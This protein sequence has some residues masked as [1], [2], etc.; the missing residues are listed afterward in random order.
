[1]LSLWKRSWKEKDPSINTQQKT[2]DGPSSSVSSLDS[3]AAAHPSDVGRVTPVLAEDTGHKRRYLDSI[4]LDDPPRKK[5]RLHGTDTLLNAD[6]E[7]LARVRQENVILILPSK[8]LIMQALAPS[9]LSAVERERLRDSSITQ[10]RRILL[11][12]LLYELLECGELA[13]IQ[14][15]MLIFADLSELGGHILAS[16]QMVMKNF[17]MAI[18]QRSRPRVLGFLPSPPQNVPSEISDLEDIMDSKVRHIYN[19]PLN[20]PAAYCSELVLIY[21]RTPLAVTSILLE[22][23]RSIDSTDAFVQKYSDDSR[24]VLDEVGTCASDLFWRRALREFN[25]SS[26][27]ETKVESDW[28]SI[29]K[30][31]SDCIRDW[32]FTLPNL[33]PASPNF[34]VTHKFLMLVKALRSCGPYGEVFRGVILGKPTS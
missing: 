7:F 31:I 4:E 34:N 25:E 27:R 3:T 18:D 13:M 19:H 6:A 14:L 5:V 8:E 2:L 11:V 33:D 30:P 10:N 24:S 22:E 17:Y 9:I 12:V 28:L 32:T 21:E 15:H 23:L 20:Q 26:S 16:I 29:R 1:M